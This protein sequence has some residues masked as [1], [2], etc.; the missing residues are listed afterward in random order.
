V[1]TS[2]TENDMISRIRSV[3]LLTLFPLV[4][5]AMATGCSDEDKIVVENV[6]EEGPNN[7]PV[8]ATFGPEVPNGGFEQTAYYG[9]D[10][11]PLWIIG[12]DP[13]GL[14][15]LSVAVL[16]VD[17]IRFNRFIARPDTSTTGCIRFSYGDTIPSDQILPTPMTLPGIAF[18][19]MLRSGVGGLFQSQ[20]LGGYLGFPNLVDLSPTL[21]NWGGGCG[22]S[23]ALVSGPFTVVPPAVPSPKTVGITYVDL[24]FRGVTVTLYDKVGATAIASY[25]DIR[26]VF[27]TPEERTAL[28]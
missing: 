3:F 28:P 6:V 26:I 16:R 1:F 19:S 21:D 11:V 25:P 14:D 5:L 13:D 9:A 17:S 2:T 15:D 8:I 22:P 27:T 23:Q 10:G 24:E 12:G 20:P 7:P 18:H 4:S